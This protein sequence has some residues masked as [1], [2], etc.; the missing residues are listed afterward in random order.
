MH[1]RAD[2]AEPPMFSP[3]VARHRRASLAEAIGSS[4]VRPLCLRRCC[5]LW[6]N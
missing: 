2:A 6:T 1:N 3:T 4:A 5:A